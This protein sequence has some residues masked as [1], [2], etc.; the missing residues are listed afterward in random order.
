[1][2]RQSKRMAGLFAVLLALCGIY[3]TAWAQTPAAPAP[4]A[5]R[6]YVWQREFAGPDTPTGR[7]ITETVVV[8]LRQGTQ[9]AQGGAVSG[10]FMVSELGNDPP[11]ALIFEMKGSFDPDSGVLK[12]NLAAPA[13]RGPNSQTAALSGDYIAVS[14][15]IVGYLTTFD[16]GVEIETQPVTLTAYRGAVPLVVGVW[17]WEATDSTSSTAVEF[18]SG[19]FYIL[20]QSTDGR[21]RGLFS[22]TAQDTGAV[23]AGE[24]KSVSR[25]T[26]RIDRI[27]FS[28]SIRRADGQGL[29]LEQLWSGDVGV[30]GTIQNGFIEQKIPGIWNARWTARLQ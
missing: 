1:M 4:E 26:E 3:Y 24:V 8:R 10:A 19:E 15:A 6:T 29:A 21:I 28:R 18:I 14:D 11:A 16:N 13:G 23:I 9:G 2:Q 22:R 20:E 7:A 25:G 30:D 12:A 17:Q 27:E 5:A